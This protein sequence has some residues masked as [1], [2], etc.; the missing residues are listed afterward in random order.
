MYQPERE[1]SAE[2]VLGGIHKLPPLPRSDLSLVAAGWVRQAGGR[3]KEER[4]EVQRDRRRG[5][6]VGREIEG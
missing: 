4:A 6:G 1:V 3:A 2:A 5:E